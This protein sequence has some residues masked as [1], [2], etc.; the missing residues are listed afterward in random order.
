MNYLGYF[1]KIGDFT[2]KKK[3]YL[4]ETFYAGRKERILAEYYDANDVFHQI[5]SERERMVIR[6][7][8]PKMRE[9]VF[10]EIINA[11]RSKRNI[12]VDYYDIVEDIYKS[13]IFKATYSDPKI[14][15]SLED[16][17]RIYG[18]MEIELVEY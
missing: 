1:V 13:G 16:E 9:E 4:K 18:E 12:S 11:I 7:R 5:A 14:I 17:I 6:W 15:R 2:L 8:T 3:H 10:R